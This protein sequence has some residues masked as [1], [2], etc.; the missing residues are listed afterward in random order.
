[1]EDFLKIGI[2][3]GDMNGIGYEVILKMLNDTR[4]L[5]LCTPIIYGSPKAVGY[6][7]KLLS[8]EQISVNII[9]SPTEA[10][11]RRIN[12]I[13]TNGQDDLKVELGK[14]TIEAGEAAHVALQKATEDIQGNLIDA[15]LTAPINKHEIQSEQFKFP[16]HTEY[17]EHATQSK[18]LMMFVSGNVRIALV[19]NHVPINEVSRTISYELIFEKLELL[20][21]TLQQ[22]FAIRRPRIAVLGLNPH[23]GDNGLLGSEEQEI[24]SPA[25][26]KAV[27][28][29]IM[30]V[31]PLAA[32]GFFGSDML[33]AYDAVLA[34]YHDQGLIPF[35]ALFMNEGVNYTAGLPIVRTSPAHGTA[36]DIAGQNSANAQSIRTAL[37]L[38][39]DIVRMRR[40]NKAISSNILPIIKQEDRRRSNFAPE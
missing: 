28:K 4:I 2:T 19:T 22:D 9:Q 23:A 35:K 21:K 8:L 17:L 37:Y 29:G 36:Y 33:G 12:I 34:M 26:A 24:I 18:G 20:N 11:P 1:M 14:P 10:L 39:C 27:E 40:M 15:I 31:G 30:C 32:D 5:E 7:K 3:H 16:G 13:N 25:I 38:A 6:Y